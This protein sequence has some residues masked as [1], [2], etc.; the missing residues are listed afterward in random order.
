M[1]DVPSFNFQDPGSLREQYN[2]EFLLFASYLNKGSLL[3]PRKSC[4]EVCVGIDCPCLLHQYVTFKERVRDNKDRFKDVWFTKNAA[5]Q[6]VWGTTNV[7]SYFQ[8]TEY[9]LH[10]RK[11]DVVEIIVICLLMSRCFGK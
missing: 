4:G 1:F 5:D 11:P 3:F 2:E 8:K 9:S 7:L 10:D 6:T